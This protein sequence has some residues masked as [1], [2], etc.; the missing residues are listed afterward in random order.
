MF[1]E[2]SA[3]HP[4]LRTTT[5]I[6][7]PLGFVGMSYTLA[8]IIIAKEQ[9]LS[10]SAV[11]ALVASFGAG[12]LL[13]SAISPQIRRKL[14]A[15][16]VLLLELWMWAVPIVFLVW[17]NVYVLGVSLLPERS[18]FPQAI[19]SLARTGSCSRRIASSV[20]SAA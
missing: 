7:A 16:A 13:G 14:P 10:G 5:L 2:G 17:P 11:G 19:P 18:R 1:R 3:D 12:V 6:F 9:G 8:V 15:R 20:A 4:F